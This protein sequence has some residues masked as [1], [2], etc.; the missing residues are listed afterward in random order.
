MSPQTAEMLVKEVEP[1][2]RSSA[3]SFVPIG[4]DDQEEQCQDA[5]V[6]AAQLLHSVEA[7]AKTGVSA[8]NVAYFAVKLVKQGRRSTGSKPDPLHPVAILS[9]RS[10]VV[11]LQEAVHY[12]EGN[13][14]PLVLGEV[15]ACEGEDPAATSARNLDWQAFNATLDELARSILRCL[16]EGR[17][18]LEVARAVGMSRSGIQRHKEQL[19]AAVAGFMGPDVL[20][21]LQRVPQWRIN[22][23][24]VR[25]RIACRQERQAG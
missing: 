15:L 24:A 1:R 5:V 6:T 10:Q 7:R 14:E 21:D 19:T 23:R 17:P 25:E 8:G 12:E 11:S 13:D 3:H 4:S 18:L 16:A 9:G 22:I 2:I 20:P